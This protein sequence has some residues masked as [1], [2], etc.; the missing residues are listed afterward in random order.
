MIAYTGETVVLEECVDRKL[1][2]TEGKT[3]RSMLGPANDT[4]G[5]W[6]IKTC[7]ELSSLIRNTYL[8]NY[9]K[10]QRLSWLGQIQRM[11]DDRVVKKLCDWKPMS[12]GLAGRP[13]IRCEND[14]KENL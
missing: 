12:T 7:D 3:L 14:I 13:K 10:T 5:T 4:D 2:I 8:I 11:A 9:I 6:S 1:L